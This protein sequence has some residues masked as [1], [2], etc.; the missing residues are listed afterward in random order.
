MKRNQ[1]KKMRAILEETG[2]LYYKRQ[3]SYKKK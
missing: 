3:K 1:I 2:E